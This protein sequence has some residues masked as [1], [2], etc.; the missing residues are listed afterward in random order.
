[1]IH[2]VRK[3]F[4]SGQNRP[5]VVLPCGGGKTVCF[6][7]MAQKHVAKDDNNKVWF[8]VHR[9]ELVDQTL[10]AFDTFGIS[11][12]NIFVGMVQ[13]LASKIRRG[14]EIGKPTLIIF[15]EA[16][17]ATSKTWQSII[18]Y[19]KGVPTLGLTATPH[20]LDGSPLGHIFDDL[21]VGVDA[22][23]LVANGFLSPY[24]YYAPK[25]LEE[26]FNMR[27]ADFD[28]QHFVDLFEEKKIYGD[29]LKYIKRDRKTIVYCPTVKFS[30]ALASMLD[31]AEHFDA[32][33]PSKERKKIVQDFRDGKIRAL[34][35]VDLIGEGFDVPDCDAVVLLRPTL[36]LSLFIQQ[37]M[38]CLRYETNK[39]AV[40][41]D[42]VGN[43]FR[44]G[45]PSDTREWSLKTKKRA[46][47]PSGERDVIA[48]TCKECLLA[49][50]GI[51]STCPFCGA[52]NGKTKKELKIEKEQ[53]LKKIKNIKKE[54]RKSARTFKELVE[55]G[56]QRKYKNPYY[57]AMQVMNGRK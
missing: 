33:T 50:G 49:Y 36:S 6:A 34:C 28:L 53:E 12:D 31:Y 51:D 37:S 15:D 16:H 54:E 35:N 9:Q 29:A 13:T 46:P 45:M 7:D 26:K 43:V 30:K 19:F 21:V 17:H 4:A 57:W 18:D 22:M 40:I 38:R 23:Y 24:D 8:L 47:N 52:D 32:D 20:R 39:R 41:Y 27:G 56:K 25:L 10:N 48:R 2:N 5:L 42:L 14:K 1:M 11:R 44:H 55:L 3:S